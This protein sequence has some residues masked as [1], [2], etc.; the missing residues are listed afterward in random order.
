MVKCFLSILNLVTMSITCETSVSVVTSA[1]IIKHE[2]DANIFRSLMS[3]STPSRLATFL[4]L[5]TIPSPSEA[6]I[7]NQIHSYI[8]KF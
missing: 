6:K 4:Y 5:S 3:S 7:F 8:P 1:L 2:M